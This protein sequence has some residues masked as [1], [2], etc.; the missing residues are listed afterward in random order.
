M[1]SRALKHPPLCTPP[2][3]HSASAVRFIDVTATAQQQNDGGCSANA[4]LPHSGNRTIAQYWRGSAS[5]SLM[6]EAHSN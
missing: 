4:A 3:A 6:G 5:R 2:V 1:R